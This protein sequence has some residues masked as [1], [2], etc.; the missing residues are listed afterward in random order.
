MPADWLFRPSCALPLGKNIALPAASQTG[1]CDDQLSAFTE[2][3]H[4]SARKQASGPASALKFKL[5]AKDSLKCGNLPP[6]LPVPAHISDLLEARVELG[7]E[8]SGVHGAVG[9]PH[10]Q[11]QPKQRAYLHFW[12]QLYAL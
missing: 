11:I 3:F 2:I 4:P 5:A 7:F 10:T 6:C 1:A 12:S 8:R 9:L